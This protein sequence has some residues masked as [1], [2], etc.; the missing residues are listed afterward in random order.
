MA[1]YPANKRWR[2]LHRRAYQAGKKK[3]YASRRRGAWNGR[4]PWSV[5]DL[6]AVSGHNVPDTALGRRIGRSVAAIQAIRSKMKE[7]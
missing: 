1:N 6:E 2:N 7:R 5:S 4:Q 3:Y